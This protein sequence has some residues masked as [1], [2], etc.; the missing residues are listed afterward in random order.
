MHT[1]D[2]YKEMAIYIE[3]WESGSMFNG[4]F[5]FS[6]ILLAIRDYYAKNTRVW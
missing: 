5:M 3:A 1:S 2:M 4:S 6:L